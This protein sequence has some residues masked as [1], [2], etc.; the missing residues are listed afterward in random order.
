MFPHGACRRLALDLRRK[1]CHLVLLDI[2][3]DLL[4]AVHAE[5]TAA[6]PLS[7]T[8]IWTYAVDVSDAA[9]VAAVCKRVIADL[10]PMHVAV[11]INNAG[12]VSCM[13]GLGA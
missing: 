13:W 6:T 5:L 3:A 12:A 9:G 2:R 11:L 4:E 10:G 8:K 1:G 7:Q